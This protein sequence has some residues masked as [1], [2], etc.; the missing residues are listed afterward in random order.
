M[1]IRQLR[2]LRQFKNHPAG[3]TISEVL[4]FH[5]GIFG[6]LCLRNW[7][8]F[9]TYKER[10]RITAYG[11]EEIQYLAEWSVNR[12]YNN[13]RLSSRVSHKAKEYNVIPIK[14]ERRA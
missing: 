8:D 9:D 11:Y 3:F 2:M 5:Q 1:T 14:R 13:H 12:K 7:I 10:F 6:T 4:H